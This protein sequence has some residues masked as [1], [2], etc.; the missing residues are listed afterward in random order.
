MSRVL[1]NQGCLAVGPKLNIFDQ[2]TADVNKMVLL[3]ADREKAEVTKRKLSLLASASGKRG[4][5]AA[6]DSVA[7]DVADD[8]EDAYRYSS[9]GSLHAHAAIEMT[10]IRRATDR[11]GLEVS[12]ADK[13]QRRVSDAMDMR[14]IYGATGAGDKERGAAAEGGTRWGEEGEE[15]GVVSELWRSSD[16]LQDLRNSKMVKKHKPK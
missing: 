15:D 4:G 14:S 6:E 10:A 5:G 9:I 12:P 1:I 3:K 7:V 13:Q 11:P 2:G 8:S 16:A